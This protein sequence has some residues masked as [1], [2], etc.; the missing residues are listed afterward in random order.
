MA[1]LLRT[2]ATGQHVEQALASVGQVKRWRAC[3][4]HFQCR[5]SVNQA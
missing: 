3:R 4:A 1:G 2:G 5:E